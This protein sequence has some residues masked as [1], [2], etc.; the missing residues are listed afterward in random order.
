MKLASWN[1]CLGL[2]KKKDYVINTL[3]REKIDI[4]LLQEVEIPSDFPKDILSSK[5]YKL[6]VEKST[7]K[8]RC[9]ILIKNDIEYNRRDDLEDDD[10]CVCV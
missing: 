6:E 3:R 1:L 9:A 5:D 10:L 7:I 4:C 2:K 8:S